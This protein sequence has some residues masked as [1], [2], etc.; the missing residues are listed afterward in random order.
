MDSDGDEAIKAMNGADMDGRHIVV[1]EA[2]PREE[3]SSRDG[4]GGRN[5]YCAASGRNLNRRS[6]L[7]IQDDVVDAKGGE[8]ARLTTLVFRA[9]RNSIGHKST[10]LQ[11]KSGTVNA[12][13]KRSCHRH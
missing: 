11:T 7:P 4:G 6:L 13:Q 12:T 8:P 5:R 10:T 1:N 2:R 9:H 3:R